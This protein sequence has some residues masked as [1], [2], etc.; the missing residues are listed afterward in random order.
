MCTIVFF[1]I[2]IMVILVGG[3]VGAVSA[4]AYQDYRNRTWL[5]L[6]KDHTKPRRPACK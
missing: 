5:E 4:A 2:A 6:Q 3:I 1:G